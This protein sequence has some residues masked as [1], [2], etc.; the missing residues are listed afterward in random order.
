MAE[1]PNPLLNL[2]AKRLALLAQGVRAMPQQCFLSEPIAVI[3]LA[4]RFPGADSP[5]QFWEGLLSGRDAVTEIPPDRWDADA[6]FDADPRAPGKSHSRWGGFL[7]R[8]DEFDADFFGI[9]PREAQHMDPRQRLLLET[10]WEA[11]EDSGLAPERLAGSNTGV[12]VGHMVGDYYQ[13][14][15][16]NVSGIDTHAG[17]GNLDAILANR[18]SY[19]LDLQGPS[20]AVD[21]AC[22]SSLVALYLACQSLRQ[23]ECQLALAGGVNLMLTAPMHVMGAKSLLLSPDGRSRAFDRGANGFVRGEGCGLVVLRRL[24]DALAAGDRV[25]AVVRGVAVS[26]DG[27]T[28]GLSAPSG[29]SQQR[30]IRRAL[31]NALLEPSRV[32]FVETHG[33]G[34]VVG[35]TVEFEALADVYGGPSAEGECHLGAVKTNVGHL[36]GAAGVAGLIKT[37]LC[38]EHGRIPPNLHLREVNPHIRVESTRLRLPR[39]SVSWSTP[40]R[41]RRGAVSSFGLGGTNAH[42]V[43]E[44]APPEA[45]PA[46]AVERPL[47]LL[48]LS[49]KDEAALYELARRYEALLSARP[50]I[51]LPDVAFTANAG[52]NHFPFRTALVA[53]SV[54]ALRDGLGRI[55]ASRVEGPAPRIAYLFPGQPASGGS[56]ARELHATQPAFRRAFEQ[57]GTAGERPELALFALQ[58]A[59]AELWRSWGIRPAL[60]LGDGVGACV[61]AVLDGMCSLEGGLRRSAEAGARAGES[62]AEQVH[63]LCE[64]GCDVVLEMGPGPS[65]TAPGVLWLRSLDPARPAWQT[66]L[67]GL[68]ALYERGAAV[69]WAGFDRGYP[70]RKVALPTYPFRR[71]RYWLPGREA[72]PGEHA[73]DLLYHL[74]WRP[75]PRAQ[76][77]AA[78]AAGDWLIVEHAGGLGKRLAARLR[79]LGGR[80][81]VAGAYR[82]PPAGAYRGVVYLC[83]AAEEADP[84]AAAEAASGGLLL[85][86]QALGR[87]GG[88]ARLWVVTCGSQAVTGAETVR[89]GQAPLWGLARTVRFEHPELQAVCV[90]LDPG[91]ADLDPL[92]AELLAPDEAQVACREGTRYVARLVRD[93]GVLAAPAPAVRADGCY[94]ITGGL[95][96]LGLQVARHLAAQGARHLVLAGR[97]A[98]ADAALAELRDRGVSVRVEAADV[99]R[100]EGA[101]RLVAACQAEGPLRGVVHAA[102]VLD[103]GVLANQTPERFARVMAPKVRGAWELHVR[104]RDLPLDFFVCFSSLASLLGSPGQGNYA[105]ANAFLDGLAHHRRARGLTGLSINWGPWAGAGMAAGLQSRLQAQGEFLIDPADGVRLFARALARDVAQLGVMHVDWAPYAAAYPAPEFLEALAA[106][107]TGPGLLRRLEEAPADRRAELLEDFVRSKAARVLGHTPEALPRDQGFAALGMDSLGAIELRTHLEQALGCRLPATLAFDYPTVAALVVHLLDRLPRHA[108]APP[109][110]DGL[111]DLTRD[112]IAALLAS[113]LNTTREGRVP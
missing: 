27:R 107:A 65:M 2:P 90:D 44:E 85:L 48:A 39:E 28:N 1:G 19:V 113:E 98:R 74:E 41:P 7:D 43:L 42:A 75:R 89:V 8:V 71:R 110:P 12:F 24:A 68:T 56:V 35:D 77:V 95:G 5:G 99:S 72:G 23:D 69:D 34:T 88:A 104:T 112:E 94:L 66:L 101:A 3:G 111:E 67:E 108:G 13:L 79:R 78:T 57:C 53:D 80:A 37:V 58:Y 51:S 49:A 55:S 31:A 46:P 33:T 86:V 105:A 54:A 40:T 32:T 106:N 92:V 73:A 11:L 22:S 25:R 14:E 102:G 83:F 63:T 59:L 70:R 16:A 61:A 103:D 38:L 93:A 64:Q 52:R 97:R 15:A 96:T 21:T 10:A 6:C 87:E 109:A 81:A 84:P 20:V 100:P 17:T 76:S 60:C 36:E 91:V 29:P 47:H 62:L 26:Q 30:V 45:A 4:C 9:S 50:E 82:P 18:L